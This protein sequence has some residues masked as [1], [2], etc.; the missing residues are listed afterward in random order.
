MEPARTTTAEPQTIVHVAGN[1]LMADLLGPRDELLDVVEDAQGARQP[2]GEVEPDDLVDVLVRPD[3]HAIHVDREHDRRATRSVPRRRHR[4]GHARARVTQDDD[5]LGP[6]LARGEPRGGRDPEA[7]GAGGVVAVVHVDVVGGVN[8]GW[9]VANTTLA[10]ER[11]GLG[12][13]SH[14]GVTLANAGT[15]AGDLRVVE[16]IKEAVDGRLVVFFPGEHHPENHT[17]RLLDARDGWNYLAVPLLAK[18]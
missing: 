3:H 12:A 16:G 5:L 2:R 15:I 1:H 6:S 4:R 18:D 17:Y 9:A 14:G 13:G 11:A 7:G 8:N 10:Y